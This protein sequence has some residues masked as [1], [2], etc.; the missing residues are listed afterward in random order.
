[1]ALHGMHASV[2]KK[3]KPVSGD[4]EKIQICIPTPP[5]PKGL[6]LG[7]KFWNQ[8]PDFGTW[9][10]SL[11]PGSRPLEL[12]AASEWLSDTFKVHIISDGT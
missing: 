9:A 6:E 4:S 2:H 3:P 12:S 10:T 8:V 5:N 11:E 7:S 1:M